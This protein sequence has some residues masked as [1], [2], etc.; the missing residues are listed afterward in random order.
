[1]GEWC[2]CFHPGVCVVVS[3]LVEPLAIDAESELV[4]EGTGTV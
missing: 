1:M 2:E 3:G 4:T